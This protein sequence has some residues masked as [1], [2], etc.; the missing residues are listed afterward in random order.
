MPS[1]NG[2]SNAFF[3][4]WVADHVRGISKIRE[5]FFTFS[6]YDDQESHLARRLIATRCVSSDGHFR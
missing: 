4:G 3:W 5:V 6:C 1:E 2:K